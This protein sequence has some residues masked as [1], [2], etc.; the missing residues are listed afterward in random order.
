[1]RLVV[2]R[3]KS[4]SVTVDGAVVSTIGPG[5]MYVIKSEPSLIGFLLSLSFKKYNSHF[6]YLL[7]VSKGISGNP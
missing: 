4:A 2:Q 1:M 5:A 3:V 7:F 6:L